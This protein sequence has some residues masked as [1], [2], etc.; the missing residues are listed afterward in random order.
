MK[1]AELE[2]KSK[3]E[4][5]ELLSNDREKIRRLKFDLSAGKVKNVREI[6]KL[7]KDVAR[8]LTVLKTKKD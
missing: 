2:K 3:K 7:R 5:Q 4:L 1:R 6:R 8:I